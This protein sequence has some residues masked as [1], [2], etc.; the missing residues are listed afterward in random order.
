MKEGFSFK[1]MYFDEERTMEV[2]GRI[3]KLYEF[4]VSFIN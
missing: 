3:K 4:P 2:F 1:V